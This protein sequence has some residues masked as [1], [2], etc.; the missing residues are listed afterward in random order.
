MAT[1]DY[2]AMYFRSY[3]N[4]PVI[5]ETKIQGLFRI[6]LQWARAP[7]VEYR[8]QFWAEL[9]RV[10]G[11]K[12]EKRKSPCEVMVIDG[13]LR[14]PAPKLKGPATCC[15]RKVEMSRSPQSR[16]VAFGPRL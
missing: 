4:L 15:Q 13:A 14:I 9:E 16:N 6:E 8:E 7:D 12:R 2:L 3:S 10:A 1:V 11:L 5:N